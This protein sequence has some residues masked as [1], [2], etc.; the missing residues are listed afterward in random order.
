[1]P[2]RLLRRGARRRAVRAPRRRRP[3]AR[4]RRGLRARSRTPRRPHGRARGRRPGQPLRRRP[5]L[6]GR[7]AGATA[8][9]RAQAGPQGGALVV[10]VD[11][12]AR[13]LR[14]ARRP[15][16]AVLDRRR[17][18]A[19]GRGRRP[20]ARGPR[21][22]ARPADR[23]A[24]RR[25]GAARRRP[26]ARRW[27]SR[28]P[29]STRPRAGCGYPAPEPAPS[30][31]RVRPGA[32]AHV[33]RVPEGDIVWR[34]AHRLHAALPARALTLSDLRW[35]SL[36]TVDL[37]GARRPA[38]S[39]P[40]Q[41]HPRSGSPGGAIR[42]S[43]CTATCGWRG[44]GTCTAPV[45][46]AGAGENAIRAILANDTWTAVGHKLGMLD[47]VPTS[48]NTSLVGHL[49]PDLLGPDWDGGGAAAVAERPRAVG[50]RGAA[51]PA[52]PRGH[53]HLLYDRDPL[54]ARDHPLDAGARRR[55]SAGASWPWRT[56]CSTSAGS[57]ACR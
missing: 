20:R 21:G 13:A 50:R 53:R 5:A 4:D 6:A 14:R 32:E 3:A 2:A 17:R 40:R 19:A 55:R 44:P 23:R 43:R 56:D 35:P 30:D 37:I 46:V 45:S 25:R 34:A 22:C 36:A 38:R 33:V 39:R 11:G 47:L 24:R 57:A 8:R 42:R 7:A 54:P 49:G 16:A 52:Q 12:D 9:S 29:A 26:P 18:A 51:G 10:L 27:P 1:M 15:H 41:A 31:V 48:R 28:P